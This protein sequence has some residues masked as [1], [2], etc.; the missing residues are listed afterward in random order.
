MKRTKKRRKKGKGWCEILVHFKTSPTIHPRTR[1]SESIL[2]R[3]SSIAP[4]PSCLI[5]YIYFTFPP[6]DS[7]YLKK[8]FRIVFKN[9]FVSLILFIGCSFILTVKQKIASVNI[10]L[11]QCLVCLMLKEQI[12]NFSS[13]FQIVKL[14]YLYF[15][16]EKNR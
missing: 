1:L 13:N 8:F 2:A 6:P 5:T 15:L 10:N 4:F 16:K 7:L 3:P 14:Y 12:E 9:K 11:V